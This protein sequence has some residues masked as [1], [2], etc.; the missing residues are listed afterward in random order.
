M[1]RFW[2]KVEKGSGCWEWQGGCSMGYGYYSFL[3]GL[4]G[5]G[6]RAHRHSY[7][8]SRGDIPKGMY[9]LHHCDNRLCVKPW[10]LFLGTHLDNMDDMVSKKRQPFGE[11]HGSV[12][13]KDNEILKMRGL[14]EKGWKLKALSKKFGLSVSHISGVCNGNYRKIL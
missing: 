12:K 7:R 6:E 10:H 11:K 9:V 2:S 4:T 1:D 5:R 8:I 3:G 14:R 13:L